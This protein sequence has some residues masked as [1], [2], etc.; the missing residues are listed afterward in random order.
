MKEF[1][2]LIEEED[3]KHKIELGYSLDVSS[4]LSQILAYYKK[5][6]LFKREN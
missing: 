5:N 1:K 6:V 2:Q 4:L 3:L